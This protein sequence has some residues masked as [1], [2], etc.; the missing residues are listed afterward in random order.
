MQVGFDFETVE[1]RLYG[2]QCIYITNISLEED[3]SGNR[4]RDA[5]RTKIV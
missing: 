3:G 5:Q 1:D 2:A 4:L